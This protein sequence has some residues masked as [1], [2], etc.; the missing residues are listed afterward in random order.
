MLFAVTSGTPAQ[1]GQLQKTS[2]LRVAVFLGARSVF[3]KPQKTGNF[4]ESKLSFPGETSRQ[5]QSVSDYTN[6]PKGRLECDEG[7][8]GGGLSA[9]RWLKPVSPLLFS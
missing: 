7:L 2:S 6:I 3:Q 1:P 8:G 9:Q 4:N 5:L